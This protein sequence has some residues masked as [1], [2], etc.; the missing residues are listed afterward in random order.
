MMD[1][2]E[3]QD[4]FESHGL[5]RVINASGTETVH[6]A[7]RCSP[8]VVAA[9]DAVLPAWVEIADLQRAAGEVIA[10][11]TGAESGMITGCSAAGIAVCVAAAMAGADRARAEQL[12]DT[13]GMK[14]R[15]ILQKGHEVNF[16]APLSQM[17][18]LTGAA[19][20][21]IGTAT[22]CQPFHLEA[23]LADDVAAAVFVISHHTVQS[24]LIPLAQFCAICRSRG[25][26]VI[27]DAAAEYDWRGIMAAGPTALVFSA[28]KAAAG[29][30]AGVVAADADFIRACLM[31]ERG[32]GRAMKAGKEGIAGAMAAL[33]QWREMDADAVRQ[34]ER[35][36]LAR[37]ERELSGIPGL[38]LEIE[39]DPPGNPF[40]RL[41]LHVA[42]AVAGFNAFDLAE[43]LAAGEVK[44]VL[45]SLHADRGY[46]LLDTRRIDE[47]ELDLVVGKIRSVF[48]D[49]APRAA[50]G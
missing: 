6:G 14:C 34:G 20:T 39:P 1:T 12:P 22:F 38:R 36:R 27:V 47:A 25:I 13:T 43:A 29:T 26:P 42:P 48:A 40:D 10:S 16:G 21:E 45:R 7:S 8:A 30:T 2:T 4:F 41:K 9:V 49:R 31:Q 11:V 15:V 24:G 18:R 28:Q 3:M 44:V 32:I 17:I 33:V 35:A 23:A 46:L 19:V 37:A 5:R 50:A